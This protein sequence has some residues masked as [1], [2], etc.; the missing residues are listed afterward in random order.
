MRQLVKVKTRS[1]KLK[2]IYGNNVTNERFSVLCLFLSY[3]TSCLEVYSC[4]PLF[5][6]HVKKRP[7]FL[8]CAKNPRRSP[9]RHIS[10]GIMLRFEII[11]T[12]TSIVFSFLLLLPSSFRLVTPSPLAV[13]FLL[14]HNIHTLHSSHSLCYICMV[15]F[16]YSHSPTETQHQHWNSFKKCWSIRVLVFRFRFWILSD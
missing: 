10:T 8:P 13:P 9:Q 5:T 14:C 1:Y 6:L 15:S 12:F 4:W 7:V 16:C 2:Q 11:S 3:L